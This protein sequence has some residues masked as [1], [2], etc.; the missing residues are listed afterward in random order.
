MAVAAA[1]VNAVFRA[2]ADPTRRSVVAALTRGPASATDLA[3]PFDMALPSFI[4]H[5][6]VLEESGV[7]HSSKTGRVRTYR[8]QPKRLRVAETWLASQRDVWEARIDR[9]DR[10][11][12]D[13]QP[14]AP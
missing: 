9:F 2:L 5:L 11:V 4:Q 12:S 13:L 7:V 3:A 14:D 10:Y 1:S 8:L 6:R